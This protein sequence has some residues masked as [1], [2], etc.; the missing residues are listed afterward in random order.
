MSI[1]DFFTDTVPEFFSGPD[2]A[3][4]RDLDEFEVKVA[5][6]EL[7]RNGG[8]PSKAIQKVQAR[9]GYSRE[10]A[11]GIVNEAQRRYR[12]S[13]A[14]KT[15]SRSK[16]P[17][18]TPTTDTG[19]QFAEFNEPG[20]G[21]EAE[22]P[23]IGYAPPGAN[24]N[25]GGRAQ[26]ILNRFKQIRLQRSGLRPDTYEWDDQGLRTLAD[27]LWRAGYLDTAT[28]RNID[29]YGPVR[30]LPQIQNALSVELRDA[31]HARKD[32]GEFLDEQAEIGRRGEGAFRAPPFT[33]TPLV[34]LE[35]GATDVFSR[36]TG[37][38]GTD[39]ERL[40]L[41][42][43]YRQLERNEYGRVVAIARDAHEDPE[44][45]GGGTLEGAPSF[46]HFVQDRLMNTEQAKTWLM[47]SRIWTLMNSLGGL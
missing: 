36:L 46:E 31:T 35:E 5:L 21:G 8:N 43:E 17:G 13:T 20:A 42:K 22:T 47:A 1:A 25:Y 10:R 29:H 11:E 39:A 26:K 30:Y 38:T 7:K 28:K 19:R 4:A 45:P 44:G 2:V 40:A 32:S 37:G 24:T 6:E 23:T 34:D 27:K 14:S 15:E 41:A 16:A 3:T 9:Y 33:P 18:S 12:P